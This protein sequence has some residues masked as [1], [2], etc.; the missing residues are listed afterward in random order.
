MTELLLEL[1]PGNRRISEIDPNFQNV[2]KNKKRNKQNPWSTW[3]DNI[4]VYHCSISVKSGVL[5]WCICKKCD[6]LLQCTITH[7]WK[8]VVYYCIVLSACPWFDIKL[9]FHKRTTV[10]KGQRKDNIRIFIEHYLKYIVSNF[11]HSYIHSQVLLLAHLLLECQLTLELYLPLLLA[12]TFAPACL[13]LSLIAKLNL[14]YTN[15]KLEEMLKVRNIPQCLCFTSLW[16][17]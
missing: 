14:N 16:V 13:K 9:M 17:Y 1:S 10:N 11:A 15:C 8:N 12:T 6:V 5:L 4:A 7:F 2:N 3:I